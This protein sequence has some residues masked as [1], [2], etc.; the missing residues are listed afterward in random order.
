MPTPRVTDIDAATRLH[1][2]MMLAI[3]ELNRTF[4]IVLSSAQVRAHVHAQPTSNYNTHIDSPSCR[5]IEAALLQLS[6]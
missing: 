2:R 4:A 6:I 3:V 5:A 1:M